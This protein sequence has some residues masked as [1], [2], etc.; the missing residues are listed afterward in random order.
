MDSKSGKYDSRDASEDKAPSASQDASNKRPNRD[1]PLLQKISVNTELNLSWIE[2]IEELEKDGVTLTEG[3]DH[4]TAGPEKPT[5]V[6]EEGRKDPRLIIPRNPSQYPGFPTDISKFEKARDFGQAVIM[7]WAKHRKETKKTNQHAKKEAARASKKAETDRINDQN[8]SVVGFGHGSGYDDRKKSDNRPSFDRRQ[9]RDRFSN[10]VQKWPQRDGWARGRDRGFGGSSR[11]EGGYKSQAEAFED[12]HSKGG[13][14][15]KSG[16]AEKG[17]LL[18][19]AEVSP[20]LILPP[21]GRD[22][23]VLILREKIRK[24]PKELMCD[25]ELISNCKEASEQYIG[26]NV[27]FWRNF[28]KDDFGLKTFRAKQ[29]A[30]SKESNCDRRQGHNLNAPSDGPS[31]EGRQGPSAPSRPNKRNLEARSAKLQLFEKEPRSSERLAS[32]KRPL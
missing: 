19:P 20:N 21:E 12:R 16:E 1:L 24:L 27:I 9:S 11:Y 17:V 7:F 13:S 15:R 2:Q 31:R 25:P 6:S 4:I 30:G 18:D 26:G 28:F 10:S 5:G 14:P 29:N 32:G 8:K 3:K 23:E 22:V